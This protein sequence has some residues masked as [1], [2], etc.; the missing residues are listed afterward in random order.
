MRLHVV[1]SGFSDGRGRAEFLLNTSTMPHLHEYPNN[2]QILPI[3][4]N[5]YPFHLTLILTGLCS[6]VALYCLILLLDHNGLLLQFLGQATVSSPKQ[7]TSYL[8]FLFVTWSKKREEPMTSCSVFCGKWV[9]VS[10]SLWY[11]TV[12]EWQLHLK[13]KPLSQHLLLLSI[14]W[15]SC[16]HCSIRLDPCLRA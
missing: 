13:I 7:D 14:S 5:C 2:P 9:T 1:L 4:L 10:M 12:T 3:L 16:Q 11:P 6:S 8:P 15:D